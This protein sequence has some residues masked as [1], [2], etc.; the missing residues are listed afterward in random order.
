[1]DLRE[2]LRW[3]LD[4]ISPE[5]RQMAGLS[6]YGVVVIIVFNYKRVITVT[7]CNIISF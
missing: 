2:I 7:K 5:P 4:L 6:T 1:M 3:M